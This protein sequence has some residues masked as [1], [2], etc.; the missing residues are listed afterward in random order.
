VPEPRAY[1]AWSD[2][3]IRPLVNFSFGPSG[4]AVQ[5]GADAGDAIGRVHALA[6]G[7]LGDAAGP[8]GGVAALA[9]RGWPVAAFGQAFSAI[10]K[11]GAQGL[12]S[13]P[14]L[15]EERAGGW[16]G[17]EW[18]RPFSWGRVALEAGGG[19]TRVEAFGLG[20]AFTRALGS[21]SGEVSLRR[22][23]GRWGWAAALDAFG[24]AGSTDGGSWTQGAGSASLSGV[25][26]AATLTGSGR[27][28]G[29]G[30]LA[31]PAST[32]SGSA[33]RR[34]SCFPRAWTATASTARAAERGPDRQK[35]E[36]YRAELSV[37][38]APVAVYGEWLRAW[39]G[40]ARPA[41]CARR[42]RRCGSTGWCPRSSAG[43]WTSGSAAR[44]SRARRRGSTRAGVRGA[45]VSAVALPQLSSRA[46]RAA[47]AAAPDWSDARWRRRRGAP[48]LRPGAHADRQSWKY[49]LRE[50][51]S[52]L[53][54]ERHVDVVVA[55]RQI[56][57][58]H[59]GD[60]V[61]SGDR[62]A[63]VLHR[64]AREQ[65]GLLVFPAGQVR[66]LL[67]YPRASGSPHR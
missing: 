12:A 41:S 27:R 21:A 57:R 54:D 53:P 44:G 61:A 45:G 66:D 30:R 46:K 16:L 29:T 23:R 40:E 24:A 26:P 52:S 62:A 4:T 32:C 17:L 43:E 67:E 59:E 60:H 5:L 65:V 56:L 10:E 42:A 13:R 2:L 35:L 49:C 51:R 7:S 20:R 58:L 48:S 19:G 38:A 39:S 1:D 15:D 31:G 36:G 22:T 6:A 25:T 37:A 28:G 50:H 9:W 55:A 3:T 63:H 33:A 11:P 14:E 18:G 47:L 34:R 64:E 8:R